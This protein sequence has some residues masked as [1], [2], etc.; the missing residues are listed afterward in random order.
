MPI[1][2]ARLDALAAALTEAGLCGA[3]EDEL[4]RQFCVGMR[5][6][7]VPLARGLL[8]VDT[9]HPTHE[10]RAFRWDREGRESA[11]I[12]YGRTNEGDRAAAWQ[13]SAG[14]RLRR[15]GAAHR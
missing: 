13:A 2:R 10:G 15:A 7:G 5:G 11:V 3:S 9:L 14:F 4:L 8:I 1:D 6:A 12:E